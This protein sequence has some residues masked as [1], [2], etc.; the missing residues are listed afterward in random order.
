MN[1][2]AGSRPGGKL[3]QAWCDGGMLNEPFFSAKTILAL[4]TRLA[5][6]SQN[7][8]VKALKVLT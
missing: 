2:L 3:C 6:G 1:F 4:F 7:V 5:L 8:A